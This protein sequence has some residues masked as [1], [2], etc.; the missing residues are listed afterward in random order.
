[1]G[2]NPP[3]D[4][5]RY[6]PFH[7]KGTLYMG[8]S[9]KNTFLQSPRNLMG[10]RQKYPKGFANE[11]LQFYSLQAYDYFSNKFVFCNKNSMSFFIMNEISNL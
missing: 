7:R 6:P 4:H 1:M 2:G 3:K 9:L 8:S 5:Q 11:P 10:I